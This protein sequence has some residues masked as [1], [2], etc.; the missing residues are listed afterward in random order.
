MNEQ[1][2]PVINT[3]QIRDMY[4]DFIIKEKSSRKKFLLA[5]LFLLAIYSRNIW[6]EFIYLIFVCVELEN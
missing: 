3:T 1:S 5:K 4:P 6:V 2:M